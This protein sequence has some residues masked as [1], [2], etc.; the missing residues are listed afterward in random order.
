MGVKRI[1]R[2]PTD[3]SGPQLIVAR[4][5]LAVVVLTFG[6]GCQTYSDQN[7]AASGSWLRGD[8]QGAAGTYGERAR[9][10]PRRDAVIWNLELGTARRAAG[11]FHASNEAFAAAEARIDDFERRAKVS[12]SQEAVALVSN[13]ASLPY[14]GRIYDKIML[15]S[16]RGLNFL[17][18]GDKAGARVEFNRV[19][20]RQE[21]AIAV[22]KRRIARDEEAIRKARGENENGASLLDDSRIQSR[23][24]SAYSHLDTFKARGSYENPYAI[25]LRG[26][27]FATH[28]TGNS[29]LETAR[30]ALNQVVAM[31]GNEYVKRDL[32]HVEER[33]RGQTIGPM[34]HVI[35]ETGRAPQRAQERIDLPLFFIGDGNIPVFTAAFPTLRSQY[36]YVSALK[37]D[38]GGHN[39][40]TILLADMEAIIAREFL[41]ELPTIQAKTIL[42]SV[43]KAAAAYAINRSARKQDENLGLL[44]LVATSLYQVAVNVADTRTWTTLPKQIQYCSLPLPANRK[45]KLSGAGLNSD[46]NLQTGNTLLVYVKSITPEAPLLVTQ[47]TLN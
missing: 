20:R 41:D 8:V 31:T 16:Y 42:S 11:E 18:L 47:T 19:L 30:H 12:V 17:Q 4:L 45:L 36:N 29:D 27:F 28:S 43:G 40:Q 22:K 26:L 35:F 7:L 15:N 21:D 46:I 3:N 25:F 38:G 1:V 14:E 44:A 34:V 39:A 37:V 33:F 24:D 13:Q 32:Q 6:I 5:C 9:K 10:A 23:L 2:Q